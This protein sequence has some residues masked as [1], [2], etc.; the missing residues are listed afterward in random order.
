MTEK[1]KTQI[2]EKNTEQKNNGLAEKNT[3]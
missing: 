2:A 3:A 1:N